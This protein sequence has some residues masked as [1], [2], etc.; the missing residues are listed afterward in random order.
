MLALIVVVC[1]GAIQAI[2]TNA[3]STFNSISN[4]LPGGS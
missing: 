2:G 3:N 4:A 1:L